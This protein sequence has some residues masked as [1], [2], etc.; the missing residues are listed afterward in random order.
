MLITGG[1]GFVGANLARHL[2][3]KGGDVVVLDD[4]STGLRSNLDGTGA[5]F[6]K[7]SIL[8]ERLLGKLAMDVDSVV[9]LAALPS[10]PRSIAQPRPS[11]EVN[12]TGTLCV[13]DAARRRGTQVILAS[14]S[15]VY[16]QNPRLPKSEDLQTMPMSPYAVSKLA[17]E[18]YALA[19]G[20]C[21]G[22]PVLPFRFF[23]IF[24]P[25]QRA[26]HAYAAVIPIFL[27]QALKNEPVL[28]HGDGRQSRD[29]TYVGTVVGVLSRA[30][31]ER[32]SSPEPINLAFGGRLTLT[33]LIDVMRQS[34]G[35]NI[36][37]EYGPPR[38]GDVKHSQA[39]A[40]RLHSL[41]PGLEP[42]SVEQGLEETAR[43]M[44]GVVNEELSRRR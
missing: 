27:S 21:Y 38:R 37:V 44:S 7:G 6:V 1:A 29:F 43:W 34:L 4:L 41:L 36:K 31:D 13:L 2:A 33:Q 11:H 10:V 25:L 32:L 22:V 17:G 8:D 9:H 19:Y 35:R 40:G 30:I 39:D 24:G 18:Q 16:G 23:N 14:S 15:S 5:E 42:V 3:D 26:D 28:V 20:V 12:V